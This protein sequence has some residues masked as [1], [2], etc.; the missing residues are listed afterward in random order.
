MK[1]CGTITISEKKN[2]ENEFR[3]DPTLYTFDVNLDDTPY[4]LVI[5]KLELIKFKIFVD[6]FQ[7]VHLL[8]LES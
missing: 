2:L 7:T 8:K 1:V 4:K 5:N 6:F 3:L